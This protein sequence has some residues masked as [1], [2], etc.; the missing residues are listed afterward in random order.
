MNSIADGLRNVSFTGGL[1]VM[2]DKRNSNGNLLVTVLISLIGCLAV[3]TLIF[4]G[5]LLHKI[6]SMR[7]PIV[8]GV[9]EPADDNE[10]FDLFAINSERSSVAA[11]DSAD[12]NGDLA[13]G[14][15]EGLGDATIN[16]QMINTFILDTMSPEQLSIIDSMSPNVRSV[17]F[18]RQRR[19][20]VEQQRL[21]RP[22]VGF[23]PNLTLPRNVPVVEVVPLSG[24]NTTPVDGC[25]MIPSEQF[26][27]A[28]ANFRSAQLEPSIL[29]DDDENENRQLENRHSQNAV[30]RDINGTGDACVRGHCDSQVILPPCACPS[31]SQREL[32][33]TLANLPITPRPG[34][35]DDLSGY[36]L[37][38]RVPPQY[39]YGKGTSYL[40]RNMHAG[41]SETTMDSER[42]LVNNQ[43]NY[44]PSSVSTRTSDTSPLPQSP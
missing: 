38:R 24:D 30:H 25:L 3:L 28:Y 15:V 41:D 34:A 11:T 17:W 29:N 26:M 37:L 23:N 16:F 18:N 19:V 35:N 42:H 27:E 40:T 6:F 12:F 13:D 10:M 14:T 32:Q 22:E 44:K 1:P 20:L 31:Q 33:Q 43:P 7:P 4:L 36:K 9:L 5:I 2:Y 21:R 8:G 39:V